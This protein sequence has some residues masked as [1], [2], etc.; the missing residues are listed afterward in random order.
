MSKLYKMVF[1][2]IVSVLAI[3]NVVFLVYNK[4]IV[5]YFKIDVVTEDPQLIKSKVEQESVSS[6]FDL[7]QLSNPKFVNLKEFSIDLTG[8]SVPGELIEED[9][10]IN[11]NG[12]IV[13]DPTMPTEPEEEIPTFE[14]GNDNPFKPIKK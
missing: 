13:E 7:S 9:P 14:V 6:F 11:E 12:E 2:I 10:I 4:K 1:I 8:F 3:L 5:S